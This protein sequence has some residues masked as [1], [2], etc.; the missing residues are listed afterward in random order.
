MQ[1]DSQRRSAGERVQGR[2][3]GRQGSQ[4]LKPLC[5][6]V[7]NDELEPRIAFYKPIHI[8]NSQNGF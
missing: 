6:P 5:H 8:V 4:A 7:Q 2:E 3:R 1:T